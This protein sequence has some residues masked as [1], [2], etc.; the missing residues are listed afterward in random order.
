[1]T[2]RMVATMHLLYAASS[3]VS[4]DAMDKQSRW[5]CSSRLWLDNDTTLE[6]IRAVVVLFECLFCDWLG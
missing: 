2:I 3:V 6:P 1:M 5:S 4:S